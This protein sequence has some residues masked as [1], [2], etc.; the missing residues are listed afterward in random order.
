MVAVLPMH[1]C[2]CVLGQFDLTTLSFHLSLPALSPSTLC[3]VHK[4]QASAVLPL[5][6]GHPER[7][8]QAGRLER[9]QN[10]P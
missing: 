6:S 9:L 3:F 2:W 5:S 10:L 7:A 1:H 8:P 4:S